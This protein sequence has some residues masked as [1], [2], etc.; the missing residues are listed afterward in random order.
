MEYLYYDPRNYKDQNTS[1][2]VELIQ[3]DWKKVRLKRKY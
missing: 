2:D 1:F 3:I